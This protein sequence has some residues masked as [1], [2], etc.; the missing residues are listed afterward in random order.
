MCDF[1]LIFWV[2]LCHFTVRLAQAC[3]PKSD[4]VNIIG[5]PAVS[6]LSTQVAPSSND[7]L[8]VGATY[9]QVYEST[10]VAS[11]YLFNMGDC[12]VKW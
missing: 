8:L 11:I 1:K 5:G 3:S 9:Y 2:C 7:Y 6:L 10:T 12:H 4:Y